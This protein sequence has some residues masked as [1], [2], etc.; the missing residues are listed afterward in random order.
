MDL[1]N[2]TLVWEENFDYEGFPNPEKWN[3]E[4]GNHQWPNKEL[5]AYT[6]KEKNLFVK[7]GLLQIRAYKEKDGEREYTSAKINTC[8]KGAW[9]Y[10]YFEFRAKLPKGVGSWPAIWMM[11]EHLRHPKEEQIQM[12]IL[13]EHMKWPACGEIDIMEHIGRLKKH[14][15]F[16]LHCKNHNHADKTTIPYTKNVEYSI[17]FSDDFHI[18]AMEWTESYI[19]YFVDGVS[20]CKYNKSDDIDQSPN[21]WPFDKEFFLIINLAV[22]GGLGGPVNDEELPFEYFVDYIKVYQ[23]LN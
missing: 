3:I 13:P 6:D 21:S 16:S 14:L 4:K 5:Q 7:D 17:D 12:G 9:K 8:S 20:Y 11:P 19:E 23:K 15:L 18:Y 1:K 10:G 22:G 2:Y